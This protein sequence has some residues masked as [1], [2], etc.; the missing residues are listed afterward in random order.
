MSDQSS[1]R[2]A[3]FVSIFL[4]DSEGRIEKVSATLTAPGQIRIG[5]WSQEHLLSSPLELAEEDL[6]NLLKGAVQAG[7]LSPDF[8]KNLSREF[9]I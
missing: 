6:V 5:C 1:P 4:G 9:E 2:N 7:I 8:I 3:R